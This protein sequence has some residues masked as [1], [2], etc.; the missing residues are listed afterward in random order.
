MEV[1][2]RLLGQG[3]IEADGEPVRLAR[4]AKT[5]ALLGFIVLHR[6]HPV[7]RESAAFALFPDGDEQ[8]ALSQLRRHLYFLNRALPLQHGSFLLYSDGQS[9]RW[10][11][12]SDAWVDVIEFERLVA[13]AGTHA[14]AVELY[15]GDFLEGIADD[16][17]LAERERLRGLYLEALQVLVAARRSARNHAAALSYAERMLASDPWR[18]DVVRQ[19][20]AL[21]Y[22]L[23]NVA[24]AL[25]TYDRFAERLDAELRIAPM[26]ETV[27]LREAILRGDAMIGST[28]AGRS[29]TLPF[30]GRERERE[31]LD[32]RWKRA[33]SG[34]GGTVLLSGEAGI[35]KTRLAGELARAAE[36]QG[37]RV[38]HGT[39]SYPEAAPYQSVL[40][41]LRAALPVLRAQ[42][43]DALTLGVV[44]HIL[45]ELHSGAA[46]LPEISTLA[47][48]GAAARLNQSLASI[49][50]TLAAAR[51]LL[52]IF[53]DL[54]WAGDATIDALFAIARR[55]DHLPVLLVVSYRGEE[56]GATHPLRTFA[57]TLGAER[58]TTEIELER[59]S[60]EEIA[61][62]VGQIHSLATHGGSFVER[63][64][65][66]SEGNA[67]FVNE[68]IAHAL[69][70]GPDAA[71][72]LEGI[73][74][75]VAARTARLGKHARE[76]AEVAAVTGEGCSIAV[77]REMTQLSAAQM[78][79][80]FNELLDRRIMR[81]TAIPHRYDYAFTHHLLGV[82]IYGRADPAKR[83]HMHARVARALEAR[84]VTREGTA[85][86][87]AR[88]YD[89][90][91]LLPEAAR[92][93][94]VAARE[95]AAVYAYDDAVHLATSAIE[96]CREK[97]AVVEALLLREESNARRGRADAQIAD[98][99]R[100]EALAERGE[101]RCKVLDRRILVLRLS[102]DRKAELEAIEALRSESSAFGNARWQGRAA[103]ALS[104]YLIATAQYEAAKEA[105]RAG[106]QH[107]D[108]DGTPGDRIEALSSLIDANVWS[109]ELEA[110]NRLI[111]EARAVATGAGDRAGIA[112][113]FMRGWSAAVTRE[114]YELAIELAQQAAD[115]YRAIGDRVGE[116]RALLNVA[117]A[118]LYFSQWQRVREATVT[119]AKTFEELGDGIGLART[120]MIRAL[121]HAR[122]GNFPTASNLLLRAQEAYERADNRSGRCGAMVNRSFVACW[123]GDAHGAKALAL[124]G[125]AL[126]S[127]IGYASGR[128]TALANLGL[129]ERDLGALD[130]AIAHM[131]E[132][133][134]IDRGLGRLPNAGD[135]A[136][137]ALAYAMRNDFA[138]ATA[139]AQEIMAC[140]RARIA[141]SAFPPIAPW[142]AACIFHWND[143]GERASGALQLASELAS[144]MADSIDVPE[145]RQTF[146]ALPFN[147]AIA[148]TLRYDRWP[149]RPTAESTV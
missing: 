36:T 149:P 119:A 18:Q 135:L 139:L 55:I 41:A 127:E 71:L 121:F 31:A 27:A 98:L 40:E 49:V 60:R 144:T 50:E 32:T 148:A 29:A 6:G 16:W 105:A 4:P 20:I 74:N 63:L 134:E 143:D 70:S 12:N 80:A 75:L 22:A 76:V 112:L 78:F 83:T 111:E 95:A 30:V 87:L 94:A 109:G 82:S 54:H 26:P 147:R 96:R 64:C 52:L 79:E 104:R 51:P 2:I 84:G 108:H 57:D 59:F 77:V 110:A 100:L 24:G 101:L 122:C 38:Y 114:E 103:T 138:T 66:F 92:W 13:D 5:L 14:A 1:R 132:A 23:G 46:S 89:L 44:S 97:E 53:E 58:R 91:N 17:L 61:E 39:T 3:A 7:G 116:A 85:R 86:E 90:G 106:L 88:Q 72:S 99:D 102:D 125:I 68:A 128:A 117:A 81:E 28:D 141:T 11:T 65:E 115:E 42:P 45:P 118:G 142:I 21:Q 93:F 47:P 140:D 34:N 130:A 131:E 107:F 129:A 120:L 133:F 126:A 19:I 9:L 15:R 113:M 43:A 10:N 8:T 145:L 73:E 137:A 69:E 146:V 37:A 136:D 35:G 67:L 48:E 124:E 62:L 33:A 25:A 56:V 123:Q